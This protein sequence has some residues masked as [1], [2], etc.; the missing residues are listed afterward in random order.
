MHNPP[1]PTRVAYPLIALALSISFGTYYVLPAGVAGSY[2]PP[3]LVLQN[4]FESIPLQA[5]AAYVLDV[6]TGTVLFEKNAETQ[7]PLASLT[8]L[9]T[10]RVAATVLSQDSTVAITKEALSQDGDSG[11]RLGQQ[12]SFSKLLEYTL[13]TSSNDGAAAIAGAAAALMPNALHSASATTTTRSFVDAMN[14][15]AQT[16]GL[17]QTFFLNPTGLDV[18]TST[19]GAYGSA[20]DVAVLIANTY[21]TT[22]HILEATR[23]GETTISEN[24]QTYTAKNTNEAISQLPGLIAGKTGYTDLA[25]GNLAVIIDAGVNRPIAIVVLG[26]TKDGRFTDV[27]ALAA[28]A[29]HAIPFVE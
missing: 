9:M 23:D 4:S 21:L 3:T 18:S 27:T 1:V 25:G 2:T 13:I 16:L 22:P 7:L 29:R 8:K 14:A 6:T 20:R 26:S 17:S 10:A 24:D 15:A 5:R 28:A 12:W 11:L 19:S